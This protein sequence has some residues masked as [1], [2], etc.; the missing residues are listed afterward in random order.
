V[1]KMT[2]N[3]MQWAIVIIITALSM[4]SLVLSPIIY[5]LTHNWITLMP[6]ATTLPL[7]FAWVWIIKRVF[8]LVFGPVL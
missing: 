3:R 1:A 7:G 2:N 5:W 6:S 4:F 8:P